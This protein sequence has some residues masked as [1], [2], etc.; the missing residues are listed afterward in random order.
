MTTHRHIFKWQGGDFEEGFK[1]FNLFIDVWK[2]K[3]PTYK[4]I[5]VS[6][7]KKL[8]IDENLKSYCDLT[9]EINYKEK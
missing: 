7:F 5:D 3:H 2:L 4:I 6:D 8:R 1:K 9:V